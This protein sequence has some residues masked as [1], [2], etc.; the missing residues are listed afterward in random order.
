MAKFLSKC[1]NQVLCMIPN[2]TQIIDGIV[3][4]VSGK[5]IRFDRGEYETKDKKEI[6]FIKKHPLFNVAIT[7]VTEQK[8]PQ[9][10]LEEYG[11][12]GPE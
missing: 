1:Q 12:Q 9:G 7:E 11:G 2:R 6:E 8:I 5:H 3:V 10:E 4:P